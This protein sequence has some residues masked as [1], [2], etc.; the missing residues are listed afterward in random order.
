MR[1]ERA[2]DGAGEGAPRQHRLEGGMHVRMRARQC[3]PAR[4]GHGA[5]VAGAVVA[6][7]PSRR[8]SGAGIELRASQGTAVRRCVCDVIRAVSGSASLRWSDRRSG[9]AFR[10]GRGEGGDFHYDPTHR[11][12]DP[13]PRRRAVWACGG[14]RARPGRGPPP[15]RRASRPRSWRLRCWDAVKRGPMCVDPQPHRGTALSLSLSLSPRSLSPCLSLS[16]SSLSSLSLSLSLSLSDRYSISIF[17]VLTPCRCLLT[18]GAV[19]HLT[20]LSESP[21]R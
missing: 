8:V 3:G 14:A 19:S 18:H 12:R 4:G 13:A 10:R 9:Q 2:W 16:L 20:A 17:S 21:V 15:V 6:R 1:W 11:R 7:A 5:M